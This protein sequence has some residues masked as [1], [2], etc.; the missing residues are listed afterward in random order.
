MADVM[1]PDIT[2]IPQVC[3]KYLPRFQWE[4]V[5]MQYQRYVALGQ[6]ME[7]NKRTIEGGYQLAWN[8]MHDYHNTV[9][10]RS[11]YEP[12]VFTTGGSLIQATLNWV[13][14]T[15]YY[16][17]YDLEV[18]ANRSAPNAADKIID[19]IDLRRE[20]R[21][22]GFYDL[23]EAQFWG[24]PSDSTDVLSHNG[25][26]YYLPPAASATP[27]FQ[28]SNPTNFS[29]TCGI[30][31]DSYSRLMPWGGHYEK[32]DQ[33]D[34]CEKMRIAMYKTGFITPSKL[35]HD[36][37]KRSGGCQI[38]TTINVVNAMERLAVAQNDALG[39]DIRSMAD[40]T[41]FMGR[42]L[43]PVPY[44]DINYSRHP[45]FGLNWDW[46]EPVFLTDFENKE[47]PPMHPAYQHSAWVVYTDVVMNYRMKH[48]DRHWRFDLPVGADL[49]Y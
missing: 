28:I 48:W 18:S 46:I 44:L 49:Q 10:N 21:D 40:K 43:N 13:I 37:G 4:N 31:R 2:I 33:D 7:K 15:G 5:A 42:E 8:L 41:I 34:L 19:L 6:L 12:D 23:F 25:I 16:G 38:Y 30:D 22:M 32:V 17:W 14:S 1:L 27:A 9:G 47:T 3:E 24:S 20:M 35:Q 39:R 11:M 36:E 26:E 29:S 45:V